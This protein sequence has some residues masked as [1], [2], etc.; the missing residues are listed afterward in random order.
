MNEAYSDFITNFK[1]RLHELFHIEN[2]INELSLERGLPPTMWNGIMANQPLAV[3][4]P[5]EYGGRG[6]IVKECL[7]LLSAASYESLALSL[8]F[9]INIALF[10]EPLAK[11]AKEE[12]KKP[13][14]DRF[15]NHQAMGG[16]MITEPDF[17]SDALNM[18]TQYTELEEGYKIEGK[19]HWQGLTGMANFW[20]V[21]ARKNLN[22]QKL[23]RDIEFFVTD[24][25]KSE[26]KI[27]VDKYFNNIGLYV[28]PYGLNSHDV[29]IAENQKLE[30]RSTGIKLMLDVLHRSRLQF[31]GMGK[32]F[33]ERM[34]DESLKHCKNRIVSGKSLAH[35]DSVQF[36]LS[37]IQAAYTLSSGMCAHSSTMSGIEYDVSGK[38]LEA[39]SM[40]ALVTDLMQESAQ[41]CLQLA[42][43][44]GYKLEHI[45]GRGVMDSRPFQIFEGSNEMLYTQI[46]ELTM[47][48]MKRKK[49][50]NFGSF[51]AEYELTEKVA[52]RFKKILNIPL[53]AD[54]AQ[55][56]MV[57]FGK[58]VARLVCL[59][60]VHDM[61]GKG[62][63]EDL[64]ENSL[65]HMKMDIKM[66]MS[67]FVE[68]NNASPI[69]DY[70]ENSDWMDFV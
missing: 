31:T 17:G 10:L 21:A 32:G 18:Q 22:D 2:N 44:S 64:Y 14:F 49:Q 34:L 57:L 6:A 36:Q 68:N 26:Q 13:I 51:I 53:P 56:Q 42:G 61:M 15:L 37:R 35:L 7:G 60:Y 39:N 16:L 29:T 5:A 3:A 67:D 47:K 19:K 50:S 63:R 66:L 20:I 25:D 65:K 23:A 69:W 52:D 54:L 40:K 27:H 4:I 41:I 12:I 43:S 48:G 70:K 58:V 28:I 24:N 11:Y 9:G 1:K 8:T 38:G 62:F 33:I 55:R 59:Q 46:A 45:G 30:Q